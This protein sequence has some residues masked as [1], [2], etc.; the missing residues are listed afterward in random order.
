MT[1]RGSNKHLG[2]VAGGRGRRRAEEEGW[3]G[4][5]RYTALAKVI[6]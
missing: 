1:I 3:G 2:R 6:P 5:H 4:R